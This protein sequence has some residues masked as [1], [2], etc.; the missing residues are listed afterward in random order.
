MY[1]YEIIDEYN[2]KTYIISHTNGKYPIAYY[3]DTYIWY[4]GIYIEQTSENYLVNNLQSGFTI[5]YV[6]H[7]IGSFIIQI[8]AIVGVRILW[9][10]LYC[11]STFCYIYTKKK[12]ELCIE[13]ASPYTVYKFVLLWLCAVHF[14][15]S[16]N[17][18]IFYDL[19]HT[20]SFE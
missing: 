7:N 8:G 18:F 9:L 20:I 19:A 6:L 14:Y 2:V 16:L 4:T 10:C 17:L 3:V 11:R 13:I 15:F 5:V 12:T 1:L